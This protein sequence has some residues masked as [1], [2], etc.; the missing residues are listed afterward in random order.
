MS[1]GDRPEAYSSSMLFQT[2]NVDISDLYVLYRGKNSPLY[3]SLYSFILS[4]RE[5]IKDQTKKKRDSNF[6]SLNLYV[7]SLLL[8]E[9]IVSMTECFLQRRSA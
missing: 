9:K 5:R 4:L 8:E 2:Q 3:L 7:L 6:Y 1:D